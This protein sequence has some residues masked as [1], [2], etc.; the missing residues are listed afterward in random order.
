MTEGSFKNL[1]D[2]IILIGLVFVIIKVNL[3]LGSILLLLFLIFKLTINK[4]LIYM[5]KGA[6]LLKLGNLKESIEYYKKAAFCQNS[7]VKA[8]KTYILLEIKNGSFEEGL[9]TLN[10]IISKR[11]FSPKDANELDLLQSI[12]YWKI[13]DIKTSLKILDDLKRSGYNSLEFYE[14]YGY[15]LIKNEDFEKAIAISTE[16]L[17][18]D[19]LSQILRANLGEVFYRIGD[20]EKACFYFNDLIDECTNFSEPYYFMG[21]ISKEKEDFY[22]AK[23]NLNK[24][25]K[26]NESILSNLSKND[27]ENALI[28]IN[29]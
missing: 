3:L 20:I 24:A 12:I 2:L 13:G 22:K 29:P 27:I 18:I 4:H 1:L 9:N 16:G 21:L 7:N 19:D 10:N 14:I 8:I 17:K 15:V 26:Y 23:E 6:K 28:T 11:K 5:F 25:L